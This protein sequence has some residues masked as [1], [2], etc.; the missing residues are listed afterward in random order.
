MTRSV[1]SVGYIE[2]YLFYFICPF[3]YLV[4]IS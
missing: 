1:H 3:Y 2:N 4:I